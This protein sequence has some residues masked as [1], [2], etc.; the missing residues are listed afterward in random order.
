MVNTL[1]ERGGEEEDFQVVSSTRAWN[2]LMQEH[3][4]KRVFDESYDPKKIT[5]GAMG[6][7]FYHACGELKVTSSL[8]VKEGD[9][10]ILNLKSFKRL[11]TS[12]VQFGGRGSE[13][14]VLHLTDQEGVEF[15][16]RT[17]QCLFCKKPKNNLFGTGITYDL[18]T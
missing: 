6:V 11:G 17:S 13:E 18:G 15:R 4:S 16:A 2:V 8:Y 14:Y 3:L 5:Q 9:I 12:D 1:L 7:S 10:F